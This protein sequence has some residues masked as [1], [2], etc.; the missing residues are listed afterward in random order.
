MIVAPLLLRLP[1]PRRRPPRS[2]SALLLIAAAAV[3]CARRAPR[4]RRGDRGGSGSAAAL[5]VVAAASLPFLISDRV[6][7]L[8]EGVYTND[9]AAQLYWTDWLQHGFG[10]EPSAVRFGYPVGPQAVAA[11][12]ATATGASLVERLQRPAAG[13]PG[14][15]RADR[16]RGAARRCR[17]G[18]GSRSPRSPGCPT[19]RPRFSPRA[20]SRRRRWRCSCSPSR[21]ASR[22]DR[23]GEQAAGAPTRCPGGRCS[24]VGL[25]LALAARVHLQ[26]P[27]ARLVRARGCRSGS[28]SRALAGRSPVEWARAARLGCARTG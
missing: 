15:D 4:R 11:I 17:P 6:G 9:H 12:A 21:S 10:P 13:D 2:S 23:A 3:A 1:G 24:G 28:R 8:G 27:G 25:L 5:I 26:R 16:A 20:P 19:S 22:L 18:A 14:A 7:V